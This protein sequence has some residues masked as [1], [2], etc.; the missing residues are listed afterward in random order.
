MARLGRGVPLDPRDQVAR[1]VSLRDLV[2]R[3]GHHAKQGGCIGIGSVEALDEV[4][5]MLG[6]GVCTGSDFC[7][8]VHEP[9]GPPVNRGEAGAIRQLDFAHGTVAEMGRNPDKEPSG[10]ER[11]DVHA[12]R[13]SYASPDSG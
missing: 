9:I 10:H 6:L 7:K 4:K 5:N 12:H 1:V 2:S 13:V 3:M 11:G 8:F